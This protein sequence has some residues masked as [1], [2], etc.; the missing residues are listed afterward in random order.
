MPRKPK[1]EEFRV[2][3]SIPW[4]YLAFWHIMI[5]DTVAIQDKLRITPFISRL[6]E[7]P[8][9]EFALLSDFALFNQEKACLLCQPF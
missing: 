9:P 3:L 1:P 6:H 2:W 8:V 4:C 5:E 7:I